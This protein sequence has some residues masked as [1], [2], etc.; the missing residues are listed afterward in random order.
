M[1]DGGRTYD[2][3][4][5]VRLRCED[6][7][8]QAFRRAA[9]FLDLAN[10]D[11]VSVQHEFGIFGG[12][13][14]EHVLE[15]MRHLR[16]PV[17][18]TL[19]TVLAQPSAAQRRVMDEVLHLSA[20]LAVMTERG[21][22]LLRDVYGVA[23]ERIDVIPHGIPDMEFVAPDTMKERFG[24]RGRKVLLTFGLLSPSKGLEHVITALP[25]IVARHDDV[26]YVVV[27]ATHPHLIREQGERYREQLTRLAETLGVAGHVEFHNRFVDMPDL[28]AFLG[29]ADIY[30]TPYLNRDQITSGTLAYAFGCGKAVLSTPYWHA[31][32]LLSH[33]RGVIVPF[34]DPAAIAREACGL[35]ADDDRREA[36]RRRAYDLGREMIW[37][38]VAARY[39]EAFRR[40][41]MAGALKPR[42]PVAP[43]PTR[44]A[45]HG[46]PP[47][48]LD[49]L[50][51]ITDSTGVFQHATYDLP[52]L[53]EG[54]CTD[55]NARAFTLMVVLDEMGLG[56]PRAVAATAVYA[57]F[58]DHAFDAGTGRFRNF[59]G[60]D[61]RWL[62]D[63]GSDD[64]LGRAIVAI[65]TCLGRSRSNSLRRWA[66]R[67]FEPALAA[68]VECTS[69]RAWAL[70]II[71]IQEY[72]R[73]LEGDRFATDIR[74]VLTARL[75]EG[76]RRHASA[77]WRWFEDVV[78][79]ENARPC[80]ALISAGRWSGDAAAVDAGID[81]L[82]WLATIQLS[83]TGRFSPVGCK[84]FLPRGG[85]AAE[86]DQ[87]PIEAQ[88]MIAAC[89]EAFHATAEPLWI[90]RAWNA[91][92][93]FRG[94]NIL[95]VSLCD[96]HTGGC[97][98]GLLEDR[99]NENQGAESTLSWLAAVAD[100]TVLEKPVVMAAAAGRGSRGAVACR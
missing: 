93:W 26:K 60:F 14:G 33:G 94:H 89:I 52:N 30:V 45:A 43:G 17:H 62:D 74:A 18:T 61:R 98:D 3:P 38:R 9:E 2:Y 68:A 64:C 72:L 19:H 67:L 84:G 69:P 1:G 81:M 54:Y 15:L 91:F 16:A 90:D 10:V 27:G 24:L 40:T 53:G 75:V 42:R 63:R 57:S 78:A 11:V 99:A 66:M 96:P 37:T 88:A 46:L 70:G 48:V 13:A 4:R 59:L 83:P 39:A 80:Q 6:H 35:L 79:Y 82:D 58:L 71:G 97:R 22:M 7:D 44:L 50:W 31:T 85:T 28:L 56:T 12:A 65:G 92:D 20:R 86:F 25:E 95:G 34:A 23:D 21:R 41:R 73:R 87:Q 55:D 100:M 5:E 77:G 8:P 51:R 49:H 36:M 47:I 29:A 32:E 76:H